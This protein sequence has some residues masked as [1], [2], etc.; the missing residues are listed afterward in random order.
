MCEVG[1]I[2]GRLLAVQDSAASK[3]KILKAASNKLLEIVNKIEFLSPFAHFLPENSV[4]QCHPEI[5]IK[6]LP[7]PLSGGL[8][9]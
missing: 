4:L 7:L 6:A 5:D 3:I 1:K 9:G 8:K 2:W